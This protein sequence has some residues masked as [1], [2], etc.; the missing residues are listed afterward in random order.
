MTPGS[1]TVTPEDIERGWTVPLGGQGEITYK[2][3][4]GRPVTETGQWQGASQA[5]QPVANPQQIVNDNLAQ[6]RAGFKRQ[7]ETL[8]AANLDP[9][10]HNQILAKWQDEYDQDKAKLTRTTAQLDFIQQA[11]KSKAIT[12]EAGE[13][14]KAGLI[15]PSS[16]VNDMYP[17]AKT[18]QRG[19][20]TPGEFRSYVKDFTERAESTVVK[21]WLSRNYSDPE[22][23]KEQY[24]SARAAYAYDTDLNVA[25]RKAFDLAWDQAMKSNKKTMTA[26]KKAVKDDPDVFTSRTYDNRLLGIAAG[27]ATGVSP[28]AKA[29]KPKPTNQVPEDMSKLSDEELRRIAGG[30]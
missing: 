16:V 9:D 24:F 22:A 18:G 26:W 27:K 21:P 4:W 8:R 5:A 2:P 10:V 28:M 17:T 12:P 15:L 29:L 14:A 6:L 20:F 13:R 19:R 23:L 1:K 30:M 25:E 7:A 11:V 3:N